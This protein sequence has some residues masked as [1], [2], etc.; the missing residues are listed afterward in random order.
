[1]TFMSV[2]WLV[3]EAIRHLDTQSKRRRWVAIQ[4]SAS[5]VELFFCSFARSFLLLLSVLLKVEFPWWITNLTLRRRNLRQLREINKAHVMSR[6]TRRTSMQR[7]K[8]TPQWVTHVYKPSKLSIDLQF[9]WSNRNEVDKCKRSGTHS[10]CFLHLTIA[11]VLKFISWEGFLA[12]KWRH[13]SIS[14]GVLT[15]RFKYHFS[16]QN[17]TTLKACKIVNFKPRVLKLWNRACLKVN[18]QTREKQFSVHRHFKMAAGETSRI[19]LRL[20][21]TTVLWTWNVP[22]E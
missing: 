12:T 4:M 8:I 1:M 19:Y 20:N 10:S 18:F 7:H 13:W 6:R 14:R 15:A 21:Q 5:S 3:F 22:E 9:H 17:S 16:R 11:S 2:K